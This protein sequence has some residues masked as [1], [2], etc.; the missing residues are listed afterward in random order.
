MENTVAENNKASNLE[1]VSGSRRSAPSNTLYLLLLL[2]FLYLLFLE[3]FLYLRSKKT[4]N[5]SS[6]YP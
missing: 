6:F 4:D 3:A 5:V 1:G 2:S